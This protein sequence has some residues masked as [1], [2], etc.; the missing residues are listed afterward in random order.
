MVAQ[1]ARKVDGG[2][3]LPAEPSDPGKR[4]INR[5]LSWLA[6]NQRVMEEARNPNHPLL[7]RLRFL[8]I[9]AANLDEFFMVRVAGL[10]GQVQ[11]GID[12]VSD[13]G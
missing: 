1:V 3:V 13:D 2:S 10:H 9:T 12:Q 7:E 6:F 8:S 5:E 4:Y 11:A